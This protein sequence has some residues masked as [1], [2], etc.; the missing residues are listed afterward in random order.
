MD[1]LP[2]IPH[3]F[4]INDILISEV[5][6]ET[7]TLEKYFPVEK[8]SDDTSQNTAKYISEQ[9]RG[10]PCIKCLAPYKI[11]IIDIN[12]VNITYNILPHLFCKT[13][14]NC[15]RDYDDDDLNL[16]MKRV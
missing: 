7:A 16:V 1:D 5:S 12:G 2:I 14:T 9:W 3:K 8:K 6:L 10:R 15:E 4:Y 11:E 13:C